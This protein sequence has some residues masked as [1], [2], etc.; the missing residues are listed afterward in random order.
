MISDGYGHLDG[1][2]KTLKEKI[3]QLTRYLNVGSINYKRRNEREKEQMK[4]N[5][6]I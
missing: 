6:M 3:E 2:K 4:W 5:G 1:A